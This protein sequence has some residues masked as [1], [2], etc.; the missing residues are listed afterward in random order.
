MKKHKCLH[1]TIQIHRHMQRQKMILNNHLPVNEHSISPYLSLASWVM[2]AV[3]PLISTQSFSRE[4]SSGGWCLMNF[5]I[6]GLSISKW[7][8]LHACP[9]FL[10]KLKTKKCHKINTDNLI[11]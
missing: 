3:L 8:C 10:F 7:G 6:S 4:H 1:D 9:P 2:Y 5:R 11:M